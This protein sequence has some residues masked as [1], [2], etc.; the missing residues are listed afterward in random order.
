[1]NTQENK[2]ILLVEDEVIIALAESKT[3]RQ[4]GYKVIMAHNGDEAVRGATGDA[5]IDLVLMD[6]DL[7]KGIDGTESARR[8][9]EKKNIPIVFLTSHYEREM[10]E[11][12]R[13]ITRYG[14]V[15]KNSGNFVLQSSSRWRLNCSRRMKK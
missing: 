4:F 13:G 11:R 15:I 6:I 3:I 8:I 5:G 10:V 2:T 9:L 12:V 7:G 14:Y 1:M